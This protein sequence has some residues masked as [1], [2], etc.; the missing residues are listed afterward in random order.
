MWSFSSSNFSSR[1]DPN[2]MHH[3]KRAKPH[4]HGCFLKGLLAF[5]KNPRLDPPMKNWVWTCR[6]FWGVFGVL[7][8]QSATGLRGQDF[9]GLEI[10]PASFHRPGCLRW[11]S[12]E[13]GSGFYLRNFD[14][15]WSKF[16]EIPCKVS[17][18][19]IL[20]C[21]CSGFPTIIWGFSKLGRPRKSKISKPPLIWIFPQKSDNCKH[22]GWCRVI[23]LRN[24]AI[25]LGT[26]KIPK[27]MV[28]FVHELCEIS[29]ESV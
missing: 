26:R 21:Q 28:A 19:H 13:L 20:V 4:S 27:V 12:T 15:F 24:M 25:I 6:T 22:E 29:M 11:F 8:K 9:W 5:P 2:W 3:L 23:G 18:I 16:L 17:S 1:L 14:D 10:W 7:K